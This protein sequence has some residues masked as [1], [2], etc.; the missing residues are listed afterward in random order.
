MFALLQPLF[1]Q[2][3]GLEIEKLLVSNH[4]LTR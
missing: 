1:K 3:M 2:I 4:V